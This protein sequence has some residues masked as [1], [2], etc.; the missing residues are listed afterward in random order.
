[1]T[2]TKYETSLNLA[3]HPLMWPLVRIARRVAPVWKVPGLGIVVSNAAF[4]REILTRDEEFTKNGPGSFAQA[5]TLGLGPKALGNMDGEEHRR[6]RASLADV[7]APERAELLVR[8]RAAELQAMCSR[9]VRGDVVDI[10]DFMRAWSGRIAFDVLGIPLPVGMEEEASRDIVALSGRMASVLGF[11]RP[12]ALKIRAASVDKETLSAY[13]RDGYRIPAPT[14]TLVG[15][16]QRLGLSFDEAA[17]ILLIFVIGGTLTTSA[18]LPRIV[19]L[20]IDNGLFG[21]IGREPARLPHV[22]DEGLRFVTPL[23]G[24]VRIAERDAVVAGHRIPAGSRLVLLTCNMARDPSLYSHPDRFDIERKHDSALG[25]LWFGA[26]PHRCAGFHLAQRELIAALAALV[27]TGREF[28][29]VRRSATR[30]ALLP[31]Y[32]ELFIQATDARR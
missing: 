25:R 20:L 31:A 2:V 5:L 22:V 1:M 24:T 15:R 21:R 14:G 18:A 30:G 6:L 32:R 29:V 23:P 16:L 10:A 8:G 27:G 19:A 28:R 7:L 26:G 9:L 13:F 11:R 3:A 4:A 17:G 12:S